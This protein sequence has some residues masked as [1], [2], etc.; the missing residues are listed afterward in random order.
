MNAVHAQSLVGFSSIGSM[1]ATR[2]NARMAAIFGASTLPLATSDIEFF[3]VLYRSHDDKGRSVVLSSLVM[4]PRGGAPKGLVL[5][6]HGTTADR[7]MSPSRFIGQANGSE[8]E[9]VALTFASGGYA[10]ALPDYQGLGDDMNAHPFPLG[11]INGRAAI[12]L[13]VPARRLA[14]ERKIEVGARLF[15]TGYSEGGGVAMWAVRQLEKNSGKAGRVFSAA[16]MAGPYDLSGATRQ[17]MLSQPATVEQFTPRLYLLAYSIDYFHRNRGVRLVNYFKPLM[18][19]TVNSVFQQKLSD[20]DIIKCLVFAATLMH[21]QNNMDRVLNPRFLKAL[22]LIDTR[23]PVIRELK[24]ND[25]AD[26]TPHT[27]MLLIC[28][29]NDQVVAASNTQKALR[30]MRARGVGADVVRQSVIVDNKL[31]HITAVV[32]SFLRARRFFDVGFDNLAH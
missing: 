3:K 29:N 14:F 22:R 6:N 4:L 26:W 27:K 21:A 19:A 9:L 10:V 1:T 2:V 11:K 20:A 18:A 32:P 25:C 16:P 23:D 15:V 7:N 13:I 5:Y 12:G 31:N 17:S 24:S 28:L 8:T 30:K